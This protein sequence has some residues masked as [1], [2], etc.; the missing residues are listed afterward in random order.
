MLI[1]INSD[2]SKDVPAYGRITGFCDICKERNISHELILTDMGNSYS[3]TSAVIEGLLENIEKKYSGKCK[4][5][6]MSNDT[7]A[8]IL[9]NTIIR[10]YGKMPED[11]KIVGF[12]NT[13]ISREAVIPISTV[14]QQIDAM[15]NE[16][17][18]LLMM[19]INERKKR[20]PTPLETPVHKVITPVI[21]RRSTTG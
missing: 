7:H 17:M 2:V 16:A 21:F 12:D 8:N 13:S 3:E 20:K 11:Y 1:H 14:G 4:G 15:A 9:L 5:I 18:E 19:Q 10:K 6:F